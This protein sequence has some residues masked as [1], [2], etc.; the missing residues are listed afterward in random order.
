[1][2]DSFRP[3]VSSLPRGFQFPLF[4]FRIS[5]EDARRYAEAVESEAPA[6]PPLAVA[7]FALRRLLETMELPPGSLHASQD[8]EFMGAVGAGAPLEMRAEVVQRSER[9]GFVAA[10][11]EF[12]VADGSRT[13]LRGRSTVLAPVEPAV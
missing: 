10:V 5:A 2:V 11:I 12:I 1:M 6:L 8:V 13:V 4:D 9:A 3:S 7:A